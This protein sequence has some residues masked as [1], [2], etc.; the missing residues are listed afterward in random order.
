MVARLKLLIQNYLTISRI[1][2]F[3]MKITLSKIFTSLL[4]NSKPYKSAII[5]TNAD[6]HQMPSLL[7]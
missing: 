2:R 1:Y 6:G 3:F 4:K 5:N 7:E